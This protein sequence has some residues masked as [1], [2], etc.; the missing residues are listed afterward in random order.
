MV[1]SSSEIQKYAEHAASEFFA[2]VGQGEAEGDVIIDLV[3]RA[4]RTER[5]LC[6]GVARNAASDAVR[7][8]LKNLLP[9]AVYDAV[10][11]E[12]TP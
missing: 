10:I 8:G 7:D 4:R 5:Y 9:G 6:A 11:S 1:E 2:R 12:S 3:A